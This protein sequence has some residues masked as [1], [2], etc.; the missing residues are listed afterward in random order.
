M[1][2][3]SNTLPSSLNNQFFIAVHCGA[4]Y[5]S[6]A[7]TKT[8]ENIMKQALVQTR[9]QFFQNSSSSSNPSSKTTS[10][11]HEFNSTMDLNQQINDCLSACSYCISILENSPFTNAGFGSNLN[12]NGTVECDACLCY[13]HYYLNNT[14]SPTMVNLH[15]YYSQLH[16]S[17]GAIY[18]VYNP[19]LMCH[20]LIQDILMNSSGIYTPHSQLVKPLFL[21]GRGALE[22]IQFNNNKRRTN[23]SSL[24]MKSSHP[25]S[26]SG[27]SSSNNPSSSSNNPTILDDHKVYD[28]ENHSL[29]NNN[30]NMLNRLIYCQDDN[31]LNE[32]M[33]TEKSKIEFNKYKHVLMNNPN[34]TFSGSGSNSTASSSSGSNTINQYDENNNATT[35]TWM[36]HGLVIS[37]HSPIHSSSSTSMNTNTSQFYDTVGA[38]VYS[39]G[40]LC[41]GV[42]SGGI[43]LKYPGRIGEA[44]IYG[45]GCS[46][47]MYHHH[48]KNIYGGGGGMSDESD[49]DHEN[50]SE[51]ESEHG[52]NNHTLSTT[53]LQCAHNFSGIG[54]DIMFNQMSNHLNLELFHLNHTMEQALNSL[55]HSCP[56]LMNPRKIGCMSCLVYHDDDETSDH[57]SFLEFGY[58]FSTES[59]G[60]GF[61]HSNTNQCHVEIKRRRGGDENVSVMPIKL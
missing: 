27:S 17:C 44:A 2:D 40:I 35:T 14:H 39:N 34:H 6:H 12:R 56:K 4:G 13:S 53:T 43:L 20:T 28:K 22:Y 48:S 9:N 1:T 23:E 51:H 7:N 58:A 60:I 21:S 25:S 31:L 38:I 3:E 33:V 19:I 47:E 15:C 42:S 29:F 32:Y 45:S 54:E 16:A 61:T 26:S 57:S 41:S 8:Y 5:H 55:F 24:L 49:S 18:G 36:N 10:S 30:N 52:E 50:D 46:S 37:N 59:M 11:N